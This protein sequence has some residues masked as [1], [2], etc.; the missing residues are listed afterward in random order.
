VGIL[1]NRRDKLLDHISLDKKKLTQN[2]SAFIQ[3]FHPHISNANYMIQCDFIITTYVVS[4][5]SC[6]FSLLRELWL[7]GIH[8]WYVQFAV[9]YTFD[10]AT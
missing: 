9:V 8:L 7:A 1:P 2:F 6:L 5:C 3:I 10:Y 4:T